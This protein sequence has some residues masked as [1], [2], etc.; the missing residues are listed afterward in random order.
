[1]KYLGIDYGTKRI[2]V[3]ISDE[4]GA[5]AFPKMIVPSGESAK[6]SEKAL[7]EILDLVQNEGVQKIIVGNSLDGDGVRNAVMEDIDAFVEELARL[8]GLPVELHDE[9]FSSTA[10]RA[11]TWSKPVATPRRTGPSTKNGGTK[12]GDRIDDQAAA[13]MLQ[14]YLDKQQ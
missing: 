8:T 14:R 9:R 7:R 10:A 11:A 4:S 1:M 6:A 5:F 13:I 12:G 2:G 3:A